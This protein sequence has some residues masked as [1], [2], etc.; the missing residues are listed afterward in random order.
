MG[1]YAATETVQNLGYHNPLE[2]LARV[3]TN[4]RF[5]CSGGTR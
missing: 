2:P 3:G 4:Q 5:S 1:E